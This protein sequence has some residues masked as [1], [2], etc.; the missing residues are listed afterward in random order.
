MKSIIKNLTS[1]ILLALLISSCGKKAADVLIPENAAMVF[2]INAAS[3]GSKLTWNEIKNSDMFK[4]ADKEGPSD[5]LKRKLLDNPETSGIDLKG[6]FYIFIEMRGN[7]AY[8]VVQGKLK[9]V[10]AYE[11]MITKAGKN[12]EIKKA[13]SMSYTGDENGLVTWNNDR[14]IIVS[15]SDNFQRRNNDFFGEGRM[16]KK[17][18]LD[19]VLKYAKDLYSLK[20]GSS[21]GNDSRF[22]S[23][24]NEKGDMHFW[25]NTGLLFQN[26][27]PM[28]LGGLFKA[29]S[30][31]EGNASGYTLNFDNGKITAST[32]SWFSKEL[33]AVMKKFKPG[34]LNTDMLKRISGQ[35][36][37]VV[38][39]MNYPPE[40]LKELLKLFGVDGLVNGFMGEVGLSIDDFVKANK[41]DL[42][43]AVSDFA[44][45]D[46]QMSF[47]SDSTSN[48]SYSTPQ[49]DANILFATSINDKP[50]FDKIADVLKSE[51]SKNGD[52]EEISKI[53]Y[54]IKDNWFI[55][56]N[57]QESVDDFAAGNKTDHAFI[58]KIS[59]HPVGAYIDL[60]K[61][62][63]GIQT[64]EAVGLNK[65]L[66]GEGN[67]WDN[68][69][70]YGGEMK[71]DAATGYFE[72][73]MI[74]KNTNSL[75]QLHNFFN[76]M[77][78]AFMN[79]RDFDM[80]DREYPALDSTMFTPPVLK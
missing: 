5:E 7:N 2:H 67:I 13:G 59:G 14:F 54:T 78:K 15:Q 3:L 55:C 74:D 42:L 43:F 40:G 10:K 57:T 79:T 39:A 24:M 30:L 9:D 75:K 1:F 26:S 38:V 52:T 76:T 45:K 56:G 47:G 80:G 8:V 16:E 64:K 23:L 18:T 22:A 66:S 44:V 50:S 72:V 61:I 31:L 20:K 33:G 46:K 48:F 51:L 63:R 70:F 25:I 65:I 60:Q 21:M 41:G 4:M 27:M 34:N 62:L 68:I 69:I 35:N 19:S 36:V 28:G 53:K 71:D 58:S 73:N 29:S 49:P 32:K 37:S 17:I 12:K 77:A 6:D 11:T